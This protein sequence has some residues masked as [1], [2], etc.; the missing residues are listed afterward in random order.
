MES[1]L[2]CDFENDLLA[3]AT[4]KGS[5]FENGTGS[6][7]SRDIFYVLFYLVIQAPFESCPIFFVEKRFRLVT[8]SS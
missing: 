7:E 1:L 2:F 5:D 8:C 4:L 3:F 6:N